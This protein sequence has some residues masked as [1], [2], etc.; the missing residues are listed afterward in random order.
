M[1]V[2]GL[3]LTDRGIEML[4]G[5]FEELFTESLA[6]DKEPLTAAGVIEQ[7]YKQRP[8]VFWRV[9]KDRLYELRKLKS[10]DFRYLFQMTDGKDILL[11]VPLEIVEGDIFE[12]VTENAK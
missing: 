7:Y 5:G 8:R 11:G 6:K 9:G 4:K 12:L 1:V 2:C 3:L 10:D